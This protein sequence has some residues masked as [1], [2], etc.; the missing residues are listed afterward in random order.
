MANKKEEYLPMKGKLCLRKEM[1][2]T[3]LIQRLTKPSGSIN[4][5]AFGGG[6][7]DGGLS[8][9]SVDVIKNIFGFDYMG[10][11]KFEF[12]RV[13]ET[14]QFI[15]EQSQKKAVIAEQ[16]NSIYYICP[17]SYQKGVENTID[18]LLNNERVMSL[19]KYCGLKESIDPKNVHHNQNVVGW[20][21]LDNGF[22]M[23]IDQ[24]MFEKTKEIFN[25]QK[26]QNQNKS[27]SQGQVKIKL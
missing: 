4:H 16:Y 21:E 15:A 9:E 3:K 6:L 5:F 22:F 1:Y 20:L 23:F 2:P 8:N 14:L 13:P 24:T 26:Q 27:K 18:Q 11:A 10:S 12:G 25:I 7:I 19:E 17:K